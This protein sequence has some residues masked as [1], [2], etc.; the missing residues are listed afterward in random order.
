MTWAF[1]LPSQG[2]AANV[3]GPASLTYLDEQEFGPVT[4][5]VD[6]ARLPPGHPE[7]DR[8]VADVSPSPH[9][10]S[11]AGPASVNREVG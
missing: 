2:R 8:L 3:L 4:G 11:L 5:A 10:G 9:D 6:M 1:R 7:L